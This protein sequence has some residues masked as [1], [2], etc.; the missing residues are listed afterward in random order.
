[1][2]LSKQKEKKIKAWAVFKYGKFYMTLSKN[3]KYNTAI[4][5]T[6]KIIHLYTWK[7]C[8]ITYKSNQ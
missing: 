5:D 8:T 6:N 2:P 3:P 4:I 7:P 1:M